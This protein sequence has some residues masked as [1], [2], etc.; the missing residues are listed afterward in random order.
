[1]GTSESARQDPQPGRPWFKKK[2]YVIP[3][4]L[5]ILAAV[6]P[7]GGTDGTANSSATT[8]PVRSTT[9]SSSPGVVSS[10]TPSA[11]STTSATVDATTSTTAST[12]PQTPSSPAPSLTPSPAPSLAPS[13]RSVPRAVA[14]SLTARR[15]VA[16]ATPSSA[17]RSAPKASVPKTAYYANCAAAKAAGAAP[18][19][20]G[21]PGYSRKLD[22]DGDGVACER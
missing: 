14:T 16:P 21:Q 20:R 8:T 2:R 7:K 10:S 15:F 9:A 17:P 13:M 18:L 3:G 11:T 22:R 12:A 6:S 1:M 4:A 19:Y 5:V